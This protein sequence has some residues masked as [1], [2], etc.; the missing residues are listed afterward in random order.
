[1][2][3]TK[4]C[5]YVVFTPEIRKYDIFVAKICKYALIDSFEGFA[6]VIDNSASYAGL[7]CIEYFF[8]LPYFCTLQNLALHIIF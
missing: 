5:R 3:C 1:M 4:V 2:N 7:P 8:H 6:V